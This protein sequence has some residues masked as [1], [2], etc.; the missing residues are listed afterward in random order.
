MVRLKDIKGLLPEKIVTDTQGR[1]KDIRDWQY[2]ERCVHN[3]LIERL[4][5][6]EIELDAMDFLIEHFRVTDADWCKTI[7]FNDV[8]VFAQALSNNLK[9]ILK[10]KGE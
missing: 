4:A 1:D 6:K 3:A 7:D 5:E 2:Y 10:L 9:D 8:Q